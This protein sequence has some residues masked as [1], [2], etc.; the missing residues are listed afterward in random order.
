MNGIYFSREQLES[1]S[2]C[3][4]IDLVPIVCKCSLLEMIEKI[5]LKNILSK[6]AETETLSEGVVGCPLSSLKDMYG[7]RII[8][9]IKHKDFKDE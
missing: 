5:K 9:K 6:I 3:L 2:K 1:V 7:K 4:H 8:T